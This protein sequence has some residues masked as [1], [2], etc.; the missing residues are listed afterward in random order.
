MWQKGPTASVV[1]SR[2][3]PERTRRLTT[4]VILQSLCYEL[5]SLLNDLCSM[6]TVVPAKD[7]K[8]Q[9]SWSAVERQDTLQ[10]LTAPTDLISTVD[11][12]CHKA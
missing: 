9:D 1:Q 6:P 5:Y 7:S 11:V 8:T 4:L 2:C 12:N 10:A 3:D